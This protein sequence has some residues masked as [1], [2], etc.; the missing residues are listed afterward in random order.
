MSTDNTIPRHRADRY[1]VFGAS[2]AQGSA[3][4]A[5]LTEAGHAVRGVSR[6]GA[7]SPVPGVEN[8]AADLGDRD[9]VRRALEGVSHVSLTI[10]LCYDPDLVRRYAENVTAAAA[11]QGVGRVV[12]N[13]NTRIPAEPTEAAAFETRRVAEEIVL[14]GPVPAVV[15]RPSLYLENLLAPGVVDGVTNAGVLAY[16]LPAVTPVSWVSHADLGR[17]IAVALAEEADDLVGQTLDIGGPDLVGADLAAA[18]AAAAGKPLRFE[19]LDPAIFEQGL[20]GFLGA[21]AAAG[22][23]GLYH[24]V[25]RDPETAV[26]SGGTDGLKKL[27]VTPTSAADWSARQHAWAPMA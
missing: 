4:V 24:W 9:Q 15:L 26:M 25:G 16:P 5:A 13:S 8:V 14:G 3:I 20:A 17:G 1:A 21:D 6:S 22:V 7:A 2:G 23:A 11:E 19:P 12:L 27:G 18:V 10:P